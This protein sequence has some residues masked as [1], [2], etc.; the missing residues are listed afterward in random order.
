MQTR[1]TRWATLDVGDADAQKRVA[2][3]RSATGNPLTKIWRRIVWTKTNFHK[4]EGR[5]ECARR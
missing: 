3:C 5:G 1:Q 4:L 2:V